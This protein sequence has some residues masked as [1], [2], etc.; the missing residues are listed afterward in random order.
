[1][2]AAGLIKSSKAEFGGDA[3]YARLAHHIGNEEAVAL[4]RQNG[5][6]ENRL[7]QA[8]ALLAS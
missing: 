1:V 3:H 7:L 6:E 2:T 8:A 4:F 5:R